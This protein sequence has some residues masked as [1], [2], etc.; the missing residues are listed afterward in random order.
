MYVLFITLLP[1]RSIERATWLRLAENSCYHR[2]KRIG[3]VRTRITASFFLSFSHRR[4]TFYPLWSLFYTKDSSKSFLDRLCISY[5]YCVQI[6]FASVFPIRVGMFRRICGHATAYLL[7]LFELIMFTEAV[8]VIGKELRTFLERK[9]TFLNFEI[10]YF[11]F[12]EKGRG[13]TSQRWLGIEFVWN[14]FLELNLIK[15]IIHHG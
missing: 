11:Y 3:R 9:M 10:F 5:I 15:Y 14:L 2:E 1:L 4:V 7:F 6:F 13:Q 8:K 12:F